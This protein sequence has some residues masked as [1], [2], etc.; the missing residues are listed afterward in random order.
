MLRV[1]GDLVAPADQLVLSPV[2]PLTGPAAVENISTAPA[3][4]GPIR[5][6]HVT[7]AHLR[8][9]V[10]DLEKWLYQ[11]QRT[12]LAPSTPSNRK[13]FLEKRVTKQSL[14]V[15]FEKDKRTTRIT[16]SNIYIY[17]YWSWQSGQSFCPF[18]I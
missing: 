16:N 6:T 17:I 13:L 3:G 9:L 2:P 11:P 4:T 18:L 15:L 8:T 10:S 14:A 7:S 12:S 5:A 1:P